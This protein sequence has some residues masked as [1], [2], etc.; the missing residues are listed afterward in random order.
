[1]KSKLPEEPREV[2]LIESNEA[3]ISFFLLSWNDV[4]FAMS[5]SVASHWSDKP[6][7]EFRP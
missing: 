2:F 7:A 1:M 3:A 4:T 6:K 5:E